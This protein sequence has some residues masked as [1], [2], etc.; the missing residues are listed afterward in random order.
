MLMVIMDSMISMMTVC[1]H[2]VD[3]Y[4]DC[5]MQMIMMIY[6]RVMSIVW[7]VRMVMICV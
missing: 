4:H 7:V 3:Y 5:Y 2:V 1:V 6:I